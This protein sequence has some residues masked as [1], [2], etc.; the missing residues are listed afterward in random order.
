MKLLHT[1][2]RCLVLLER[3]AVTTVRW[4]E[5]T[6]TVVKTLDVWAY[7]GEW[8]QTPSLE[9]ERREY[10]VLATRFGD[11]EVFERRGPDGQA[12]W[13]VSRIWD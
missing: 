7:R 12:G 5:R 9:G 11:I 13:W 3:G 1:P 4:R 8:W 10:H 6:W 2:E